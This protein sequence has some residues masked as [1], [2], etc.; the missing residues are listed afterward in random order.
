MPGAT[1]PSPTELGVDTMHFSL[2]ALTYHAQFSE[3][4]VVLFC[5][6]GVCFVPAHWSAALLFSHP[7]M[8]WQPCAW[9]CAAQPCWSWYRHNAPEFLTLYISFWLPAIYITKNV[10]INFATFLSCIP[11]RFILLLYIAAF[12]AVFLY[13]DFINSFITFSACESF[14][15]RFCSFLA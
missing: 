1:P 3:F 2:L 15:A 5:S 14:R 7:S 4:S 11:V 10:V 13:I 12:M 9:S 8:G 6:L